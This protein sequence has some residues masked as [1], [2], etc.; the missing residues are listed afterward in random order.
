MPAAKAQPRAFTGR[1]M[2]LV[3]VGFFGVVIAANMTM[4][5]FALDS[6]GGLVVKNSYVASQQF[7]RDVEAARAMP[8]HAWTIR[9]ERAAGR[10]D[11]TVADAEGAPIEGVS[12]AA[13]IGRRTH[14]REDIDVVFAE[15]GDGRYRADAAI[16]PG[17]WRMT[18]T[19]DG[20]EGSQSRGVEL[21]LPKDGAQ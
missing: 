10:L 3:M 20:I 15:L 6:F 11:I 2:L 21:Y 17:A 5:W 4:L 12:L 9:A 18:L 13:V 19:S 14:Q 16:G 7:D 1:K 8:I